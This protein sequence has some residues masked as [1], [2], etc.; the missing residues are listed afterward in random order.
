MQIKH[1]LC[2][3]PDYRTRA[4]QSEEGNCGLGI[5]SLERPNTTPPFRH[6]K[7]L[8]SVSGTETIPT[9]A[10]GKGGY[11]DYILSLLLS[12]KGAIRKL[13]VHQWWNQSPFLWASFSLLGKT[14][15]HKKTIYMYIYDIYDVMILYDKCY[16]W[17]ERVMSLRIMGDLCFE[18]P[19]DKSVFKVGTWNYQRSEIGRCSG[20]SHLEREAQGRE[21]LKKKCQ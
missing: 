8:I 11:L 13:P 7:H 4:C 15:L 20:K 16:G 10:R 12:L 3:S 17:H 14:E 18:R 2:V 19:L 1:G 9:S 6:N 21:E 5:K